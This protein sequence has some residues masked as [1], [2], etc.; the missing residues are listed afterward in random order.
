[1]LELEDKLYSS[2]EVAQIIG[3]SLRS[4]Y[5]YLEEGKMNVAIKTVTGRHRFS[6][7]NILDFLNPSGRP[8]MSERVEVKTAAPKVS[9]D[10]NQ[11]FKVGDSLVA[12]AKSPGAEDSESKADSKTS[13]TNVVPP[14][15]A[16]TE[17]GERQ[18][19]AEIE[20]I[21]K[22]ER[23]DWLRRFNGLQQARIN[24]KLAE[25]ANQPAIKTPSEKSEEKS[26]ETVSEV[27]LGPTVIGSNE[28]QKMYWLER[29][30]REPG[31][32]NPVS[33]PSRQEYQSMVQRDK[34]YTQT[35]DW[36]QKFK[37]ARNDLAKSETKPQAQAEPQTP[38]P[39]QTDLPSGL[40]KNASEA[41]AA[42]APTEP[43]ALTEQPSSQPPSISSSSSSS[44]S[45]PSLS[46]PSSLPDK[47]EAVDS[48]TGQTPSVV[49]AVGQPPSQS[50]GQS[51]EPNSAPLAVEKDEEPAE[52][53]LGSVESVE[54]ESAEHET[55]KQETG[56]FYYTSGIRGLREIANSLNSSAANSS[57]PYAFTLYA[58]MSL[59]KTIKP[60]SVLHAYIK[61]EH[62]EFFEKALQLSPADKNAAQLCLICSS[63]TSIFET[64]KEMH[65]LKVTSLVRLKRDLLEAGEDELAG[66]LEA[67][68]R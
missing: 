6:K 67:L 5:R 32:A 33:R 31:R 68:M 10:P 49:P 50:A 62:R 15:A 46:S 27:K 59:Y 19:E 38:T 41:E 58:G 25:E 11:N 13:K 3:V 63:D 52:S 57:S 14:L 47:V 42:V 2:T 20:K 8:E 56:F 43:I 44:P 4:I 60:F 17:V 34:A 29:F 53:S 51:A 39:T 7:E 24:E 55:L 26:E 64:S 12:E 61:P 9:E 54:V 40:P 36:L 28:T 18:E 1:M 45:S 35:V 22:I 16:S 21:E 37:A 66:S 65:G 30:K 48:A 23:T